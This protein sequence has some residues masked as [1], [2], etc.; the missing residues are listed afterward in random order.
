MKN[1][2]GFWIRLVA[3]TI[4][5]VL[6]SVFNYFIMTPLLKNQIITYLSDSMPIEKAIYA[7]A[8]LEGIYSMLFFVVYFSFM[9][10]RWQATLGKMIIGLKVVSVDG[11]NG[12]F[13]M[14]IREMVKIAGSIP[15]FAGFIVILFNDEKQGWH[16]KILK[17]HVVKNNK[18][19]QEALK[20][21]A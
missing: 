13:K 8:M 16:D 2:A 14:F 11:H 9:H 19:D 10:A 7:A 6:L 4:D 17:T 21:A 15:L 18:N 12:F 3:Y 1:Y 20:N 5:S